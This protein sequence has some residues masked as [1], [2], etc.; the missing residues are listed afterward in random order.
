M[1]STAVTHNTVVADRQVGA[2]VAIVDFG[3]GNL[4]SVMQACRHAG[5]RGFLTA[6]A[7]EI[8]GADAVIL[9]GIGAFGDAMSSLHRLDLVSPLRDAAASGKPL[10]GVCL[11]LQLLMEESHEFGLHKGLGIVEGDVIA[12]DSPAE[13]GRRL[14]VPQVGWN[15]IYGPG[16]DSG[17]RHG[18][19]EGSPLQGLEDGEYMYFVHSLYVRPRNKD[20]VLSTSRY[21]DMEFCSSLKTGNIFA[22]QFHPERSGPEGLRI[23]ENVASALNAVNEERNG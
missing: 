15:R 19:W 20:L 2:G 8:L 22:C 4:F 1:A 18:P 6:I 14:K 9:P 13:N 12:F 21:G 11:G 23:Y 3:L 10:F 5:L 16:K 7:D 17:S